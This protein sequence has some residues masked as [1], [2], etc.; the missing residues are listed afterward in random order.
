MDVATEL[1][2]MI[3]IYFSGHNYIVNELEL[4]REDSKMIAYQLVNALQMTEFIMARKK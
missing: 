4:S 1:E 3:S 2:K